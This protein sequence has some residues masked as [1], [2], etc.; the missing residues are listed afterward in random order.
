[1]AE[2]TISGS[3]NSTDGVKETQIGFVDKHI[4]RVSDFPTPQTFW[5]T[6]YPSVILPMLPYTP[7]PLKYSKMARYKRWNEWSFVCQIH[8]SL[9]RDSNLDFFVK[10]NKT[11][12][13]LLF[14]Q[15]LGIYS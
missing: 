7:A 2:W 15:M 13:W 4:S 10:V 9:P 1:M 8:R 3:I 5:W 14:W 11:I 6:D 12:H